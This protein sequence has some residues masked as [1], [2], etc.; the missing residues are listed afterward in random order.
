MPDVYKKNLKKAITRNVLMS[1]GLCSLFIFLVGFSDTAHSETVPHYIIEKIKIVG[2]KKTKKHVISEALAIKVGERLSVE[3]PA[4]LSAQLRLLALGFFSDVQLHL[5]R[6]T[7]RGRVILVVHV[8]ERGT[9]VLSDVFMGV[10]EATKAWGGL[11]LAERNFLGRGI[12][13]EGAFVLGADP[14]IDRGELQQSYWA[15]VTFP[16]LF[17]NLDFSASM[18]YLRGSEF[19]Q[20]SGSEGS[21]APSDFLSTPYRRAG[22]TLGVGFNFGG[23]TRIYLHYRSESLRADVPLAASWRKPDGQIEPIDFDILSDRS[24][25]SLISTTIEYDTRSDPV[26]PSRGTIFRFSADSALSLLASDYSYVKLSADYRRYFSIWRGHVLALGV[27]GGVVFG[28]APFFEQFFIGDINDLVPSR[29]LGLN[30]ST[31]SSRDFFGTNIDSMRY[32][33]LAIR[34]SFQYIIPW[35]RGGEKLAYAGDFFIRAGLLFLA[36]KDQLMVRERPFAEAM[37]IDLTFDIGFQLD[38]KVGVFRITLGNALGR[39]PF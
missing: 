2:A 4:F 17:G 20:Q 14:D 3:D 19:F 30:F 25:L 26:L 34:T 27:Y 6:G 38:T 21:S 11:G 33:E 32:E 39:I 23:N 12:S 7:A 37:P 24:F 5:E 15:R 13:L 35:F 16:R 36:S 18:L 8:K 29:S 10:S 1:L 9:I 31:L 28:E 22:G